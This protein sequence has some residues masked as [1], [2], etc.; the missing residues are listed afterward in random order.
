MPWCKSRASKV[1]IKKCFFFFG[2]L[3]PYVNCQICSSLDINNNSN[4]QGIQKRFKR[5]YNVCFCSTFSSFLKSRIL[6]FILHYLKYQ[7]LVS[8]KFQR[9]FFVRFIKKASII[10]NQAENKNIIIKIK[11][12][13]KCEKKTVLSEKK[14]FLNNLFINKI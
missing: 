1:G 6:Y 5:F 10:N 13:C 7:I 3:I 4:K 14:L 8:I 12:S 2:S 9:F 11:K